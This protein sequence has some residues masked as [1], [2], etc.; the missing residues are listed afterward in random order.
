MQPDLPPL[1]F[2]RILCYTDFSPAA[3]RAFSF[4]AALAARR[5]G[6]SLT[7]LHVIPEPPAQFWKGYIYG[8]DDDVDA[9]AKSEIDARIDSS[10]RPL[11]PPSADF[12]VAM[13]IGEPL[14]NI[15]DQARETGADLLVLGRPSNTLAKWLSR[16][17]AQRLDRRVACPV[18][19]VPA[20][21]P[22][23]A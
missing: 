8:V 16:S 10:Y 21:T 7:L 23:P 4:A 17:L 14:Q 11:V 22:S 5:P 2:S 3:L 12:T 6:A 15:L 18:L 13:R 1:P 9:R 20:E 19:V